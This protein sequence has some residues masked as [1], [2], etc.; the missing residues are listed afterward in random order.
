MDFNIIETYNEYLY[1][2]YILY[3]CKIALIHL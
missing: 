3:I 1:D 2:I